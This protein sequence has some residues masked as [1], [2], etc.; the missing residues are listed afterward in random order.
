MTTC[1]LVP[2]SA[3]VIY[4]SCYRLVP[5]SMLNVEFSLLNVERRPLKGV[6][7]CDEVWIYIL[8]VKSDVKRP[9]NIERDRWSTEGDAA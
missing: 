2:S 6:R 4:L 8:T 5:H 3:A 1:E 9:S 7:T